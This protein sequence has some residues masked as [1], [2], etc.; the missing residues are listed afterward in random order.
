[1]NQDQSVAE[2]T[3]TLIQTTSRTENN[4]QKL[5]YLQNKLTHIYS[6]RKQ[7]RLDLKTSIST[8]SENTNTFLTP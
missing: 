8:T 2:D 5:E 7:K 3:E 4:S 6:F 1:M